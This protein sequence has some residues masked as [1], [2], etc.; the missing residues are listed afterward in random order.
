[1]YDIYGTH[2]E[3]LAWALGRAAHG[4]ILEVGIGWWSTPCLHGF[5]EAT[6]RQL[7]SVENQS[8]W[9][10]EIAPIYANQWHTFWWD[11][12]AVAPDLKWAIALIDGD[13]LKRALF[14]RALQAN[15]N[16]VVVHDTEPD[17]RNHYPE[18]EE[19]LSEWPNRKD[20]TRIVPHTAVVWK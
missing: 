19:A 10:N 8:G 2:Q 5:C 11:H 12:P 20:F 9:M 13:A 17:S 3:A 7:V 16:C 14:I 15:C 4:S 1:M 6:G 18:M